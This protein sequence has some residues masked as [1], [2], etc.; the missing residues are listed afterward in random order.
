MRCPKCHN[1]VLQKSGKRTK[2][3]TQGPIEFEDGVCRTLC[4]WC[5]APVE[6]PLEIKEGTPIASEAFFVRAKG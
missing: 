3:R 6:I 2:L 4:F 1:H 5:K